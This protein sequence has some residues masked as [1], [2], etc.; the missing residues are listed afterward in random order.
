VIKRVTPKE[1]GEMVSLMKSMTKDERERAER[2]L[3]NTIPIYAGFFD[4]AFAAAWGVIP[5]TLASNQA[6]IWVY[7]TEA[8]KGH[9]FL[10]IRY[11]Q[12]MVEKLLESYERIVG[13]TDIGETQSIRWLKLLGAKYGEPDGKVLP[14]EIRRK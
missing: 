9:E 13:V 3:R 6:Y 8:L 12:R 1:I 2:H 4:G 11:S 5:P 7:T 14:F 10:F